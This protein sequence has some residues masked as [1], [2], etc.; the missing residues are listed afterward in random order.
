MPETA[1]DASALVVIG[2]LDL[3]KVRPKG[4]CLLVDGA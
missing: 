3:Q 4:I 2:T 1:L